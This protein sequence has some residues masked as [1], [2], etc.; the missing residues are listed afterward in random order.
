[1]KMTASPNPPVATKKYVCP[2][3]KSEL[4]DRVSRS[5]FVKTFLFWLPLKRF[6]CYKCRRKKYVWS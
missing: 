3:C 4:R 1:M 5:S 6:S 2:I